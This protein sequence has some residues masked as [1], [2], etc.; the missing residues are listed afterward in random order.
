MIYGSEAFLIALVTFGLGV[1]LGM[2]LQGWRAGD[3]VVMLPPEVPMP[4]PKLEFPR[5]DEVS[6]FAPKTRPTVE[7]KARR[8]KLMGVWL[9]AKL[10]PEP[11]PVPPAPPTVAAATKLPPINWGPNGKRRA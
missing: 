10:P 4:V 3:E 1:I 6:P 2:A 7:S 11:R 5:S 9:Q 8:D